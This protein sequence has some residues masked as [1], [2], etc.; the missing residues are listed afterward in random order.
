MAIK[1]SNRGWVTVDDG[2]KVIG[3]AERFSLSVEICE[4]FIIGINGLKIFANKKGEDFI[5]SPAWKDKDGTFHNYT[6]LKFPEDIEE[7]II[8]AVK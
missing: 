8:N 5:S 1:K 3:D 7:K 6:F 4:G 2:I